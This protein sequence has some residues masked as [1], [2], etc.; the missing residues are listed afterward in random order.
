MTLI[1]GLFFTCLTFSQTKENL[2]LFDLGKA[3]KE[4]WSRKEPPK[5]VFEN[6]KKDLPEN[7]KMTTDFIVQT[8]TTKNNLLSNEFLTLP[9]ERTLKYIYIIRDIHNNLV[10]ENQIDYNKLIDTLLNKSIPR[11]EL[12][13]NYYGILIGAFGNKNLPFDLS[14]I[15][16]KL[17]DFNLSNETENGIFFLRWIELCCKVI[18]GYMYFYNPPKLQEVYNNIILFPRFNGKPYYLYCDLDFPDFKIKRLYYLEPQSYKEY[19]INKYYE[20]LLAH[21]RSL[22]I[23]TKFEKEKNDL[24]YG[25]I[26]KRK[27]LYKYTRHKDIIE[28]IFNE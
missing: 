5:E 26:L 17:Q 10:E 14:N 21:F 3:H 13:D 22:D 8:I 4:F 12:V 18:H 9:D 7:L 2:K 19:Y 6:L 25:S 15:D 11:F 27:E 24:L 16:F 23:I 28:G 20:V 1:L